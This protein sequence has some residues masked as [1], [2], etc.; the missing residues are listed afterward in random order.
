MRAQTT[1]SIAAALQVA[2]TPATRRPEPEARL[3]RTRSVRRGQRAVLAAAIAVTVVA[4]LSAVPAVSAGADA[5]PVAT[6]A[7]TSRW[8]PAGGVVYDI[9]LARHALYAVGEFKRLSSTSSEHTRR[10]GNVTAVHRR[11]GAPLAGFLVRTDGPVY[12]VALSGNGRRLFIGGDFSHVNGAPHANLAAVRA[13]SGKLVKGWHPGTS[14]PVRDLLVRGKRVFVGG[15]FIEVGGQRR[16]GLAVVGARHGGVRAY[17][18]TTGG[19][20]VF[21]MAIES[22]GV[23]DLGGNFTSVNGQRRQFLARVDSRTGTLLPWSAPPTC[24]SCSVSAVVVDDA[25]LYAGQIGAGGGHVEALRLSDGSIRWVAKGNGDVQ[26]LALGSGGDLYVGGHFT[27]W[28][29]G[30]RRTQVAAVSTAT[31]AVLPFAPALT[32]PHP[33]VF[34]LVAAGRRVF[35][36]GGFATADGAGRLAAFP[37]G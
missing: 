29:G 2:Q 34:A 5:A 37:R 21:S 18:V 33:G 25:T 20:R 1:V 35:V 32:K 9:A 31:G 27:P 7:A 19:G 22:G 28:F 15:Q 24:K 12:A 4:G 23:L 36:G 16:L 8:A 17:S 30:K 13:V 11:S 14:G 3:S 10:A 26:S 6:V